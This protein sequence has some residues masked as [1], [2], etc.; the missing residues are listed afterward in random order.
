MNDLPDTVLFDQ[1]VLSSTVSLFALL[2]HSILA[3]RL[4]YFNNL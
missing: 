3:D 2:S 1:K 4:K